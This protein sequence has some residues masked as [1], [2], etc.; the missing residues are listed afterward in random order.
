MTVLASVLSDQNLEDVLARAAYRTKAEVEH[1]VA[2][3]QPREA[4]LEG[5]R[6]LSPRP[7]SARV[8]DQPP[9]RHAEPPVQHTAAAPVLFAERPT[10]ANPKPARPS[11]QPVD[12]GTYSLRVTVDA[13]LKAE[14]DELTALLSHKVPRGELAEVLREA[15]R[16]AI[17]KHG[18]RKGARAPAQERR[19]EGANAPPQDAAGNAAPDGVF[20]ESRAGGRQH[21]PAHVRREVWARDGG[22]CTWLGPDGQRCESR[23]KLELDHVRPV[24]LGGTSDAAN[25][26]LLCRAHNRLHAERVFGADHIA[27]FAG[28]G[29]GQVRLLIPG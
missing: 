7:A 28:D 23:W 11:I 29:P 26:R 27:R 8:E 15:I 18:N 4:P 1:V 16:C 9:A 6:R 14:L 12:A 19:R 3:L 2:T 22:R 25:L 17:E 20:A 13:S 5:V 10:E 21:V 24:A